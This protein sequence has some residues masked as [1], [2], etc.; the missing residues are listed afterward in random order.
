MTKSPIPQHYAVLPGL[1]LAGEYPGALTPDVA[2]PRVKTLVDAGVTLFVDLTC[3]GELEPYAHLVPDGREVE[4]LRFPI[5]DMGIPADPG[6]MREALDAI[7]AATE[8]GGTVYVHCLGGIG[9]TGTLVGCYL[10]RRGLSG[11]ESLARVATLYSTMPKSARWTES[12]QTKPQRQYVLDWH[13]RDE[14]APGPSRRSRFR[15]ALLGLAVGDALGTTLEFSHPGTFEPIDDMVGG[16]PFRLGPGEWTDDTAM[17][18][19]SAASLVEFGRFDA[20]DHMDRFVR[21]WRDGYMSHNARCFDIGNTVSG[22]LRRYLETGDPFAGPTDPG[23]A[24]NGS[25][26]RL[27]PIVLFAAGRPSGLFDLAERASR[28]THGAATCIDACRYYAGLI[29]GALDGASRD[30]LLAPGY[31]NGGDDLRPC[32]EID[33]VAG[34][35]FRILEPPAIA[36]TGYVVK[37]LEAARWAFDRTPDFRTGALAA[38]NLG[39]DADTTGAVFGQLA[40]AVYG[41]EGIPLEWLKRLAWRDRITGLADA[42][43]L[44]SLRPKP[45]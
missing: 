39:D 37:S 34:G 21:W 13:T 16:G 26:M 42:L 43:Y 28:L 31:S 29:A 14:V 41:E 18:L 11:E 10:A 35:S 8:A 7:D 5:R 9:R 25:L 20:K 27:A 17:A 32:P 22:A 40:G 30:V 15:G 38:V 2:A 33:A 36:G 24:G 1:L 45:A 19:C 6:L 23:T 44:Q 12:P 3:D 4:H